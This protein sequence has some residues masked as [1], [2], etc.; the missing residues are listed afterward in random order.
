MS[1]RD[2][3]LGTVKNNQPPLRELPE[4][5][6]GGSRGADVGGDQAQSADA[7][8]DLGRGAYADLSA[9]FSK[10]LEGIGGEVFLVSGYD[11]IAA[12]LPRR[13]PDARRI[14][15]GCPELASMGEVATRY[16]DPHTLE[17]VD[18]AILRAHF[19]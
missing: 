8:G 2:R 18:L 15:A 14:V 4:L 5:P 16:D 3:I 1:S 17:D 13:H 11:R 12:V 10:M 9:V 6:G 19:G 7:G